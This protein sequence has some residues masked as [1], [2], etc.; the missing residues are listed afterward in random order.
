MCSCRPSAVAVHRCPGPAQTR[1]APGLDLKDAARFAF[2]PIKYH[3]LNELYQKLKRSFWTPESVDVTNDARS[4]ERA[5]PGVRNLVAKVLALFAQLDGIVAENL[6]EHFKREFKEVKECSAFFAMQAANETIHNEMYSGLA[7]AILQDR[8]LREQTLASIEHFAP[9]RRIADLTLGWMDENTPLAERIVGFACVE[10][11]IF[12]GA[13]C[14]IHYL[15]QLHLFPGL[16]T[17]NEWIARDEGMHADFAVQLYRLSAS[18]HQDGVPIG[19]LSFE[20]VTAIIAEAVEAAR[21]LVAAALPDP[22]ATPGISAEG[23]MEYVQFQADELAQNLGFP[24][25]YEAAQPYPW[26]FNIFMPNKTNFFEAV[27]TSYSKTEVS[28]LVVQDSEDF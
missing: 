12:S 5:T 4:W 13:F 23:L 17:A 14:A 22:A 3:A 18:L 6:V 15:K 16:T 7:F 28:S 2:L 21:G 10:G 19:D 24:R 8:E 20:R 1:P 27:V 11:I 9:I 25:I 26:M